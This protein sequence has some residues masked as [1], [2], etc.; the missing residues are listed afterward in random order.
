MT[1][2]N[3][4]ASNAS[5]RAH[6][7]H[8]GRGRRT[9]LLLVLVGVLL[10]GAAA[11]DTNTPAD[12]TD[13]AAATEPAQAPLS[14]ADAP[15]DPER[16]VI[17]TFDPDF[18]ASHRITLEVPDGYGSHGFAYLKSGLVET[19]VSVAVRVVASVAFET[20]MTNVQ[21]RRAH[22]RLRIAARAAA[23][24][25]LGPGPG[26]GPMTVTVPWA[27]VLPPG[28]GLGACEGLGA[29]TG[30]LG[31]DWAMPSPPAFKAATAH[32]SG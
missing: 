24:P 5:E 29:T 30:G 11:C 10:L 8:I 15:A 22:M 27:V 9:E 3:V 17:G 26:A 6:H 21:R 2:G 19:G 7:D 18:D 12:A 14:P 23:A 32:T 1:T 4:R 25:A 31:S 13:G 16:T 28:P 20:T